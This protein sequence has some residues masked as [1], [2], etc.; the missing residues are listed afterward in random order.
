MVS[1][2]A[3][4]GATLTGCP[5]P[6]D[7]VP[8]ASPGAQGLTLG[9]RSGTAIPTSA[10][11]ALT[12]AALFVRSARV[13]GDAGDGATTQE[14]VTLKW[15]SGT[16]PTAILFDQAPAGKYAKID[17]IIGGKGRGEG[18]YEFSGAVRLGSTT[19]RYEIEDEGQISVSLPLPSSAV[20]APGG[21]L[22]VGVTFDLQAAVDA[23]DFGSL[24]PEGDVFKIDDDD[25]EDDD[26]DDDEDESRQLAAVRAAIQSAVRLDPM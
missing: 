24:T 19:Y 14:K 2:V 6:D 7:I 12:E 11:P 18:S 20:L 5:G 4:V 13:I 15:S 17:L 3:V 22:R 16:S 23:V 26:D 9:W 1:A 10:N 21:S 8:D 25:D